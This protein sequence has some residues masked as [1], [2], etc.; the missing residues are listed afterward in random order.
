MPKPAKQSNPDFHIILE[1]SLLYS[2]NPG[3]FINR[4]LS[5]AIRELAKVRD[6]RVLWYL[7]EAVRMEREFQMVTAADQQLNEFR[8]I[9]KLL[10]TDFK[11]SKDVVVSAIG[12]IIEKT[13]ADHKVSIIKLDPSKVDWLTLIRDAILRN[14]PFEIGEKEKGFRDAIIIEACFQQAEE[15]AAK[16]PNCRIV[17][18][19][20]DDLMVAAVETRAGKIGKNFSVVRRLTELSSAIN[21]VPAHLSPTEIRDIL[22]TAASRFYQRADQTTL[23]YSAKV[24]NKI[25]EK[26][27]STLAGRPDN[28]SKDTPVEFVNVEVGTPTFRSK[29]GDILQFETIVT[30]NFR[31]GVTAANTVWFPSTNTI[32]ALSSGTGVLSSPYSTLGPSSGTSLSGVSPFSGAT[33]GGGTVTGGTNSIVGPFSVSAG[34]SPFTTALGTT[35]GT[36]SVSITSSTAMNGANTS[37]I[38]I[39]SGGSRLLSYQFKVG[40]SA[41]LAGAQL[42]EANLEDIE[43]LQP[44]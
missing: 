41:K 11:V 32:A 6:V 35:N 37:L 23:Y 44:D 29:N 7:P 17:F 12:S 27:S 18:L 24:K 33:I 20:N 13:I 39:T 16:D 25:T 8:G 38:T 34:T 40:W 26:F 1:S 36:S 2:R 22:S 30:F 19:A 42:A 31:V 3:V 9:E 43:A 15:L 28:I 21:A 4:L 10:Q 5:A 14:P